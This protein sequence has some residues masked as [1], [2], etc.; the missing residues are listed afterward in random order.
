MSKNFFDV[1]GYGFCASDIDATVE[2]LEKLLQLAPSTSAYIRDYFAEN[3]IKKPNIDDYREVD[4]NKGMGIAAIIAE[5]MEEVEG[6]PFSA[7]VEAETE[8][9]YILYRPCFPWE[10]NTEKERTMKEEEMEAIFKKYVSIFN[11]NIPKGTN[12]Y[13]GEI[14]IETC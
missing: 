7:C 9:E 1:T 13:V 8:E 3:G 12:V 4:A 6:I 11:R 14:S 2:A 10:M 5:A